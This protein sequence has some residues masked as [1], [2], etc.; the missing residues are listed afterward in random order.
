MSNLKGYTGNILRIDLSSGKVR[1]TPTE[2][3]ADLFIGGRGVGCKIYWEEV[4]PEVDAFDPENRLIFMTGP[5]CGIPGFSGARWQVCA[6]SPL[7]NEFSYCNLGGSWGVFLKFAGYDTL[8]VHGKAEKTVYIFIDGDVVELRDAGHL[9]G[10]GAIETREQLKKELGDSFRIVTVGPAGE[11]RVAFAILMADND[12]TGGSGL[13]A[14]MGSKNL[15]AI[16]VHGKGKVDVASPDRVKELIKTVTGFTKGMSLLVPTVADP[17]RVKRDPCFGCVHDCIRTTFQGKSGKK[18]KFMCQ[19]ALFY[20]TRAQRY[21]KEKNEVPFEA[22]KLCDDYGL[23]T[24]AVETM[25]MWLS[26]C[27]KTNIVTEEQSGLPLSKIGSLEFI[28]KLT[29]DISRRDGFGDLLANGT[30]RAARELGNDAE[31]LITD[32]I[33]RTGYNPV[34]GAR[35]FIT[36]AIF[37]A[38]EP[39][40]PIQQLHE[41]SILGMLWAARAT[42][43]TDNYITSEVFRAIANRFW[44]SEIA[45]DFSTYEGK[46]LAAA[47]IQ[48]RQY[49]KE[50]LILCDF[51]W[52]IMHT[53]VNEDHVGDP[54]LESKIYSAVTGKETDEEGLYRIG[55]RVFN[56]QRAILVREGHK[57]REGDSLEEFNFTM[58]LKGDFL[59]EECL[60]PGKDGE[61]FSR[62]GLVIDRDEFEKMKHEYYGFRGWDI[63]TGLQKTEKLKEL[64]LGELCQEPR[65]IGQ[66]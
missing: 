31:N 27:H 20:E 41:V 23:D 46:A 10:K 24:H 17:A 35:M 63:S 5:L 51:V 26:R 19:A 66:G 50:S 48:N 25:I 65:I 59:N 37:Y 55:E 53:E 21:Y 22:T 14:V 7:N 62:R 12:A 34:Y 45:A 13:G 11:N 30:H 9:Q 42:G 64:D 52:P 56:L 4:P 44:G 18:G 8:V 54:T 61:P 49:A 57:G 1:K 38:L 3:Y 15:K 32:Y 60:L 29:R 58:P 40:L 16:A 36:T 2:A 28:E 43:Y 6:K 39:R 33:T 47:K